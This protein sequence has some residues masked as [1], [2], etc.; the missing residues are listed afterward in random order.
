MHIF[1]GTL[2]TLRGNEVL[3]LK[4]MGG[5]MYDKYEDVV[6]LLDPDLAISK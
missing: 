2:Q 1:P 3:A 5:T 4:K 6:K